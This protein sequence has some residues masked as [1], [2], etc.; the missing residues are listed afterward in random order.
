MENIDW[1]LKTSELPDD[2]PKNNKFKN[3]YEISFMFVNKIS[4]YGVEFKKQLGIN[5][6]K[7]I[8]TNEFIVSELKKQYKDLI[9]ENDQLRILSCVKIENTISMVNTTNDSIVL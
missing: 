7:N 3:V 5:S 1:D 2:S 6:Y 8:L 9:E 4:F